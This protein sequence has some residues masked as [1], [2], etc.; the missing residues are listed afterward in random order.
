MVVAPLNLNIGK[1][2]MDNLV[3]LS[4]CSKRLK[5]ETT[6]Q[7]NFVGE[8]FRKIIFYLQQI[9]IAFDGM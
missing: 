5:G 1:M 3:L 7:S 4:G 8:P 2:L 9:S 6:N